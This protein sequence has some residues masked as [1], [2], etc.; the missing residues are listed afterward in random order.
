MPR[1]AIADIDV[2]GAVKGDA[3]G[4]LEKCVFEVI[5]PPQPTDLIACNIE[6][7]DLVAAHNP[8][9][10]AAIHGQVSD[11]PERAGSAAGRADRGHKRAG[12]GELHRPV[13]EEL[14]DPHIRTVGGNAVGEV[15]VRRV[16]QVGNFGLPKR[17]HIPVAQPRLAD[18]D[19]RCVRRSRRL[20]ERTGDRIPPRPAT[21]RV[22]RRLRLDVRAGQ[23]RGEG[24]REARPAIPGR[25]LGSRGRTHGCQQA[26]D[27]N[28]DDEQTR[29]HG[30][31]LCEVNGGIGH[32]GVVDDLEVRLGLSEL[33]KPPQRLRNSGSF[34]AA[35]ACSGP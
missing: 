8:G 3:F 27:E 21:L 11:F 6:L 28:Q 14:T 7:D 29:F 34:G 4:N 24:R 35:S 20:R 17:P 26:N 18:G 15:D 30:A 5:I 22:K 12:A 25:R 31:L 19:R 32:T 13:T 10:A 33:E 2:A 1:R 23:F 16:G 9:I